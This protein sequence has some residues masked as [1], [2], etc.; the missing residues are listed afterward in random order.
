MSIEN[1]SLS[2]NIVPKSTA[3]TLRLIFEDTYL[4]LAHNI[5]KTQPPDLMKGTLSS[6]LYIFI[7]IHIRL[8]D[9]CEQIGVIDI[10]VIISHL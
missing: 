8:A 1:F 3:S 6:H 4:F 2:S 10:R 5:D 9:Q 7:D